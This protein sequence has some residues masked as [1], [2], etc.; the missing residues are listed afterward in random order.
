M[1]VCTWFSFFFSAHHYVSFSI[2]LT[3]T[4][5]YFIFILFNYN[6][7]WAQPLLKKYLEFEKTVG[8]EER[9]EYVKKAALE[10]AKTNLGIE[11]ED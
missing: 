1:E 10:Y 6:L 4:S 5:F 3:S 8:D 2:F 7:S 11:T 9:I